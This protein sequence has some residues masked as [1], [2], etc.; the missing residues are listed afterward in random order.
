MNT[1]HRLRVI[2]TITGVLLTA[3]MAV[4]AQRGAQQAL[5]KAL[6]PVSF[7]LESGMSAAEAQGTPLSAKF[8]MEDNKLQLSVYTMKGSAF[9]E[10]VVEKRTALHR[11]H[12]QLKLVDRKSTR[13]NSSH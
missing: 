3:A 11:V 1:N 9:S 2:A 5:A 6:A 10:V 12:G 13:L 8:E 4:A 7:S